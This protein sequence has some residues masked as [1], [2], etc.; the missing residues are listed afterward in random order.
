MSYSRCTAQALLRNITD[1]NSLVTYCTAEESSKLSQAGTIAG[2]RK[3]NYKKQKSTAQASTS[4]RGCWH[5]GATHSGYSPSIRAN[6]CK[7]YKADCG[8]CGKTGHFAKF[9][10]QEKQSSKPTAK[11]AEVA[12]DEPQEGISASNNA[13]EFSFFAIE[14]E[15]R[16]DVLANG[17]GEDTWAQPQ[18]IQ[19]S[20]HRDKG[21]RSSPAPRRGRRRPRP[22]IL[23]PTAPPSLDC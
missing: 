5:C 2:V 8:N 6:E 21:W 11:I 12:K 14:V 1:I 10:K 7:A 15:N 23:P 3:S 9:C 19:R 16:F 22:A 13:L 20:A 4:A 18:H 17:G